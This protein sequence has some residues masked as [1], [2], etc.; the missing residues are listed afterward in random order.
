MTR[1]VKTK[2]A[3]D[4]DKEQIAPFHLVTPK[5]RSEAQNRW[6]NIRHTGGS[7]HPNSLVQ[8]P[9]SSTYAHV[10][11]VSLHREGSVQ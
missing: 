1:R 11:V 2:A 10:T 5:A 6:K 4:T 9:C 7:G 3:E 8:L